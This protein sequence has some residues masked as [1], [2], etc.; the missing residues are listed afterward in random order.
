MN[1]EDDP[2]EGS[3]LPLDSITSSVVDAVSNEPDFNTKLEQSKI[4]IDHHK[5]QVENFRQD[6]G[7]RKKY[8]KYIFVL[9]CVWV[10]GVYA[11]MLLQGFGYFWKYAFHLTDSIVLAAIGSTTANIVGVFLI[12]T[13]YFFP[14]K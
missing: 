14:K 6:M 5:A 4:E 13:R 12:V 8:A 10:L 11:L 1:E 2:T 3:L 7:Q 9:T